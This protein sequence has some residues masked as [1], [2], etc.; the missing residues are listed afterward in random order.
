MPKIEVDVGKEVPMEFEQFAW[1]VYELEIDQLPTI[2]PTA[3][4]ESQKICFAPK[5]IEGPAGADDPHR[6]AGR[7]IKQIVGFKAQIQMKR[8]GL[9]AGLKDQMDA[10]SGFSTEDLLG[11]RIRIDLQP[12][13]YIDKN[14]DNKEKIAYNVKDYLPL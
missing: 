4:G 13:T 1:G 14:D 3:S 2:E 8:L 10:G 5:V 7:R 9:A 12:R 11:K 6:F